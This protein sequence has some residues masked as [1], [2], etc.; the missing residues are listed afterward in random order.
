MAGRAGVGGL[1]GHGGLH[2]AVVQA[3]GPRL[4]APQRSHRVLGAEAAAPAVT[5]LQAD[6]SL[7]RDHTGIVQVHR[8]GVG[9]SDAG[10]W[11]RII[12]GWLTLT[13]TLSLTWSTEKTGVIPVC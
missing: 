5:E 1:G 6:V 13:L 3:G 2:Q 9:V 12:I 10:N 7:P 8:A 11:S 4:A